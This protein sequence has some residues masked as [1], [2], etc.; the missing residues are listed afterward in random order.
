VT[1]NIAINITTVIQ[2][3]RRKCGRLNVSDGRRLKALEVESNK[4]KNISS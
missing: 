3:G 2:I 1:A 4:F